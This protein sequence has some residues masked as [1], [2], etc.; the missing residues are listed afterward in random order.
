MTRRL[1]ALIIVLSIA[2]FILAASWWLDRTIGE[3]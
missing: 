1:K 3:L 2:T